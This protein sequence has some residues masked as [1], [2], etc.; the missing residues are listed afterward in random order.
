M[1]HAV[2]LAGDERL[3]AAGCPRAKIR[4]ATGRLCLT[5]MVNPR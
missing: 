5:A 3:S 1:R 4:D 2:Q